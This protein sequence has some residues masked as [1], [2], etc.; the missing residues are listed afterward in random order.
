MIQRA[1]RGVVR[2]RMVLLDE[3]SELA[4]GTE[5]F[6]TPAAASSGSP[7]AVLEAVA[8]APPVPAAWVDDLEQLIEEGRRTSAAPEL[9]DGEAGKAEDH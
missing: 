8:S 2:G 1:A 9:F 6:V 5:V 7:A 3:Q 4:E